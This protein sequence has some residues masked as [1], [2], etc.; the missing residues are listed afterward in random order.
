LAR[1]A[2]AAVVQTE[3]MPCS[4]LDLHRVCDVL[5]EVSTAWAKLAVGD[6]LVLHWPDAGRDLQRAAVVRPN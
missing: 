5:E 3:G 6:V 2:G 1:A 4:S